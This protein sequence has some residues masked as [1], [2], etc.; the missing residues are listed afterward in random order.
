MIFL[1]KLR[2]L[3]LK[4]KGKTNEKMVK[5]KLYYNY[6]IFYYNYRNN[7]IKLENGCFIL[8]NINMKK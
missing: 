2:I 7:F 4:M 5:T 8:I 1:Q 3:F 6:T